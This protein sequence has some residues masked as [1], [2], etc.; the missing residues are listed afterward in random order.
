[1]GLIKR[2]MD[3]RQSARSVL[4]VLQRIRSVSFALYAEDVLLPHMHPQDTGFYVDV[5]TFHPQVLSNT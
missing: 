3:A 1:M 5:G 2:L 4:P